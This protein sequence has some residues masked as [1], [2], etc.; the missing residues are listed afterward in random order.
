[1]RAQTIHASRSGKGL[2]QALDAAASGVLLFA[3]RVY[4]AT[5]SPL[6]SGCCRFHPSCSVYC[7]EAIRR[8]GALQGLMLGLRRL[9]KCHPLHPGGPDPV[10]DA[11]GERQMS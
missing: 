3:I 8:H 1:M 11:A 7:A 10:P 2:G 5:L 6:F 9:L 4:R